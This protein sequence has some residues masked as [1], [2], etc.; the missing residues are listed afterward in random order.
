[1]RNALNPVSAAFCVNG[2]KARSIVMNKLLTV[3][4]LKNRR[5]PG[6]KHVDLEYVEPYYPTVRP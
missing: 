5:A 3:T 4:R 1:M 2:S 6:L